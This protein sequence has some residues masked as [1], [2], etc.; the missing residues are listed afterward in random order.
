[1]TSPESSPEPVTEANLSDALRLVLPRLRVYVT[2]LM[3]SHRDEVDDVLQETLLHVWEARAELAEIRRFNAWVFS[4]ARF[5]VLGVRR[6]MARRKEK[7]L[8]DDL[9]ETF[10][11][12]AEQ[13]ADEAYEIR[14]RSLEKCVAE[15]K[16][17]DIAILVWRYHDKRRL[18]ELAGILKHPVETIHH[19][20]SRLRRILRLCVETK[21]ARN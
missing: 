3:G 19:R 5:K 2:A 17:E 12:S 14:L 18:T 4:I 21:L 8:S 6:D 16:K 10:D 13:L 1:M 15:L 7:F 20:I 11:M 9:F